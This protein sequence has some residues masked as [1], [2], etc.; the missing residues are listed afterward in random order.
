MIWLI[1]ILTVIVAYLI[2]SINTSIILSKTLFGSDIRTSG[3]GNAGTTNMLRTHGKKMAIFTLLGDVLKGVV[4]VLLAR[5]AD[6]FLVAIPSTD[7][8][9]AHI[10]GSLPYISGFFAVLGHNYPVFFGFRGGKGVATTLGVVLTTNWQL[11]LI[12]LAI[13]LTIMLTTRY[14]S[15]GSCI[16]GALFPILYFVTGLIKGDFDMLSLIFTLALGVLIVARHQSNIKR[17]LSGTE[18]KLSF[19]KE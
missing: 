7:L 11:G 5:L 9:I 4:A 8:A 14:V 6:N 18:N 10:L 13:A 19:K 3:S 1:C 12:V 15:L 17:L 2:G 16:G